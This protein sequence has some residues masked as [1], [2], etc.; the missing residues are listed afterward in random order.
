MKVERGKGSRR[1]EPRRNRGN[2][3]PSLGPLLDFIRLLWQVDHGLNSRSKRMR[4]Q[5]GVTGPQRFAVRIVSRFPGISAGE[6]AGLLHVHPSTLTGVL[7]RLVRRGLLSRRPDPDDARR[8]LLRVTASGRRVGRLRAGT[9]EAGVRSALARLQPA[10]LAGA[11]AA[12][13]TLAQALDG[14]D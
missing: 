7:D 8:A 5:F 13:E 2:G 11:R 3:Q 6:L 14:A 4:L 1:R 9:I 10:Q 12:L